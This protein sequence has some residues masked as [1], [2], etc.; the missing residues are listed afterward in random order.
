MSREG[1]SSAGLVG[2]Y[3]RASD[4]H[5][6]ALPELQENYGLLNASLERALGPTID[7]PPVRMP[8]VPRALL[9][10]YLQMYKRSPG[11][12]AQL[13]GVGLRSN[14][15]KRLDACL[16]TFQSLLS[17]DNTREMLSIAWKV[18]EITAA[19]KASHRA[20]TYIASLINETNPLTYLNQLCDI[21][22]SR[23][24]DASEVF[25]QCMLAHV[26]NFPQ[27]NI[28][29]LALECNRDV[30]VVAML[31]VAVAGSDQRKMMVN[32]YVRYVKQQL[33]ILK[34]LDPSDHADYQKELNRLT[35]MTTQVIATQ[36]THNNQLLTLSRLLYSQNPIKADAASGY[37]Q[38]LQLMPDDEKTEADRYEIAA[39]CQIA[40]N[41]GDR[42]HPVRMGYAWLQSTGENGI[43]FNPVE[44]CKLAYEV[45]SEL[46]EKT[47]STLFNLINE[48][49]KIYRQDDP[50]VI[51]MLIDMYRNGYGCEA[52][53]DQA[54]YYL[55][56]LADMGDMS[57]F[58]TV[59]PRVSLMEAFELAKADCRAAF[60]HIERLSRDNFFAA[61]FVTRCYQHGYGTCD[62]LPSLTRRGIFAAAPSQAVVPFDSG[63]L[64][65]RRRVRRF[66][67][68]FAFLY[69]Q[70]NA[71][72][73]MVGVK[74]KPYAIDDHMAYETNVGLEVNVAINT[75]AEHTKKYIDR[76]ADGPE[77]RRWQV[78]QQDLL[79]M[80]KAYK[81]IQLQQQLD[82]GHM[83]SLRSGWPQH[84]I[85][86]SVFQLGGLYYLAYS[87]QGD[88]GDSSIHYFQIQDTSKL[89]DR[90][91]LQAIQK[92][93]YDSGYM[94]SFDNS[95]PGLAQDLNLLM[96]C[97]IDKTLQSAGNCALKAGYSAVL[98]NLIFQ[99]VKSNRS[100][101]HY[102][103][104]LTS[105]E[106][107]LA[108]TH[109]KAV[110]YKPW[111]LFLRESAME[112][113]CDLGL[114]ARG[115]H[116]VVEPEQHFN[117]MGHAIDAVQAKF[118]A[119][120]AETQ[121]AR[122]AILSPVMDFILHPRC[123]YDDDLTDAIKA[124]IV[125]TSPHLI[126]AP[127]SPVV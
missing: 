68:G 114:H 91:W 13:P 85:A 96:I 115:N 34:R 32:V 78:I 70:I 59:F 102:D 106:L 43:T 22:V 83:V 28:L 127:A 64:E 18:T 82:A 53:D 2:L 47:P 50:V 109:T 21:Q 86:M 67:G 101:G 122:D 105:G 60:L 77:K 33:E 8:I 20:Q 51:A 23:A 1:Y 123:H 56:R 44:A 104:G 7:L 31:G 25:Q 126:E 69:L 55:R 38:I 61:R 108:D 98:H 97:S 107:A 15:L 39:L 45:A 88:A 116:M 36:D 24:P 26:N 58:Y 48:M 79:Y 75:V 93:S 90:D 66:N 125:S 35:S 84:S 124:K 65:N 112:V 92:S 27:A 40:Y 111:R 117:L 76:M 19:T 46:K 29:N 118:S 49:H 62:R 16:P 87:N 73:M 80:E 100:A 6:G 5:P 17:E 37:F 110:D 14:N 74:D 81:P 89:A 72:S 11:W 63:M 9:D 99:Q 10:H 12:Y 113:L 57:A 94:T 95:L 3:R 41:K 52:S 54:M 120:D 71:N 119:D 42:S 4:G 30:L 103:G 121:A